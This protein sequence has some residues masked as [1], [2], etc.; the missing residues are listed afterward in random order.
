[1]AGIGNLLG[2]KPASETFLGLPFCADPAQ[3]GVRAAILGVPMATPY[4]SAGAYCAKAPGVIR[5]AAAQYADLS[6]HVNFDL[7]RVA[8]CDGDA[9][10]CGDLRLDA[11][12]AAGNRVA[13]R[14][15]VAALL[16]GGAA[17][18]VIGGDDS[19]PIP[20][21]QG[22]EGRGPLAVLQ[23]DAHIDWREQVGGERWGLSSTMRRA[24][25]MGHVAQIVQI[26]ARGL[27]SAREGDVEAA[28]DWGAA[29]IPARQ[30]AQ[31][32]VAAALNHIPQGAE[33]FI[34]LDCDALDPSIMPAVIARTAGG[35][36]YATA[37]GLIEGAAARGRIAGMAVTEFMPDH[38]IHGLGAT[39][40]AQLLTAALGVI[41]AQG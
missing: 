37:L 32:G 25:E 27:G 34:V 11:A 41:A 12:N 35:L 24:S 6:G 33:I 23:I 15:A 40:A 21:L 26:G 2:G 31:E 29:I 30:L 19:V 16:G 8:L 22:Y 13:I 18:V 17:P 5:A 3:P 9:A 39:L 14:Q 7:G 1:M 10:D 38:D 28:R 4:P 36:D 20:V